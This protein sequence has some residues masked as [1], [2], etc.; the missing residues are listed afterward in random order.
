MVYGI[1]LAG[2]YSSRMN[3]NKMLLQWDDDVLINQTI[4]ELCKHV[5]QVIVVSGHYHEDIVNTVSKFK[6]VK[7]IRNEDYQEGMFKSV[8]KGV[9]H[10]FGDFFIVPGDYPMITGDV[11][12]MLMENTGEIRVPTYQGYKGH[13]IFLEHHLK[14]ALLTFDETSNLKVFRDSK[15]VHYYESTCEGITK[16][17]DT[18]HDYKMMME[19]ND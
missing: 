12:Q 1:V 17:I 3:R 13:P 2:G 4:K 5:D 6:N 11:Y 16:D 19:R 8:K 18:L 9:E 15:D 10:V 14:D 7:V